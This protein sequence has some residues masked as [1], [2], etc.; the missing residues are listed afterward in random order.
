MDINPEDET[1]HTTQYQEAVLKYVEHEYCARQWGMPVNELETSLSN[2]LIPSATA[3]G[4]SQSSFDSYDLSSDDEEYLMPNDVAEM[5]PGR[6]NCAACLLTATRLCLNS[7]PEAPKNW[8]QIDP[9]RN[10][11]HSNPMENSSTSWI[12]DITDWWRQQEE[13]HLDYT[14]LSNAVDVIFYIL[15]HGVRVEASF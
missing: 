14:D 15:P 6:S 3:S 5:T 4:S 10:D 13:T 12:L 11:Y 8:G 7:L 1:S 2:K 9:K